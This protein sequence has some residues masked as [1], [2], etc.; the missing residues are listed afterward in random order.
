M[1]YYE[2]NGH[3]AF[4]SNSGTEYY[5]PESAALEIPHFKLTSKNGTND[6]RC[7]YEC[8]NL[9]GKGERLVVELGFRENFAKDLLMP[10][11]WKKRGYVDHELESW[12]QFNTYVYDEKNNCHGR[13]NP[14]VKVG[15]F[16]RDVVDFTLAG[17]A[18]HENAL[19]IF[20]ECYKRFMNA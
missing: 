17:E 11:E 1:E 13:Y 4:R 5:L 6:C 9:N 10:K 18:T 3:T 14:M 8:D 19:R 16:G 12:W 2:K 20:G 7:V 15:R